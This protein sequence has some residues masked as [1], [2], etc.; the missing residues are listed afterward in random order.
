MFTINHW[1]VYKKKKEKNKNGTLT[2][3]HICHGTFCFGNRFGFVDFLQR[4][5]MKIQ[6]I[7]TKSFSDR[8]L[9]DQ[10]RQVMKLGRHFIIN[11]KHVWMCEPKCAP[12]LMNWMSAEKLDE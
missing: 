3:N 6:Y 10:C 9:C 7:E 4:A 5:E 12:M 1:Y 11:G 8:T 2:L